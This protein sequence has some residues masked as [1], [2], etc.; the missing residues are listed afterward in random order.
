MSK[1]AWTVEEWREFQKTGKQPKEKKTPKGYKDEKKAKNGETYRIT[2][3]GKV[4]SMNEMKSDH[5]KK[6]KKKY[7]ELKG[8][9]SKL[10]DEK[11][12]PNF[13]QIELKMFYNGRL[14]LDN[15]FAS[16]KGFLDALVEKKHLP[17][18]VKKY[19]PKVSAEWAKDL[20]H[21]TLIF[22]IKEI[23]IAA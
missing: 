21:N 5:W 1:R 16:E 12:L 20:P 15:L 11:K 14:D 13:S 4:I 10:I 22:E 17:D 8:K 9:F 18:D 23:G 19:V 3:V 7:D 6:F 2:Y